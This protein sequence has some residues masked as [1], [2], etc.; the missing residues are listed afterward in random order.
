[1]QPPLDQLVAHELDVIDGIGDVDPAPLEAGR[2]QRIV[3]EPARES[4]QILPG[5]PRTL[6]P[7]APVIIRDGDE[8]LEASRELASTSAAM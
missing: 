7:T 1:V 6:Q 5:R 2:L 3:D 8:A 4:V